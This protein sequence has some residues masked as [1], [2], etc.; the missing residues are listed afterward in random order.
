MKSNV[1]QID[2][3]YVIE[4]P[5]SLTKL[6]L[7]TEGMAPSLDT[8]ACTTSDV[9]EYEMDKGMAVAFGLW[10]QKKIAVSRT[11]FSSGSLFPE[12]SHNEK[13]FIIVYEGH[14][15]IIV[16]GKT[17]SLTPGDTI[18]ICPGQAHSAKAIVD[19]KVIAITVPAAEGF[20][21]TK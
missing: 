6:K 9:V 3:Q 5:E 19:T 1:V 18:T 10:K 17:T 20:P 11:I 13:E 15:D 14:L 8:F 2:N 7:M 4:E 16:E 12:H 21:E